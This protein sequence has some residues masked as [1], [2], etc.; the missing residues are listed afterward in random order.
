MPTTIG[1]LA[2]Q[3]GFKGTPH[4][5][6]AEPSSVRTLPVLDNSSPV[7]SNIRT[8]V[9]CYVSGQYVQ[10]NGN[11][12]EVTQRYTIFVAYHKQTQFATMQQVR[13]RIIMDFE[14]KY[15][16]TFNVTNVFVP[17]LPVPKD[18]TFRGVRKGATGDLFM[19]EGSELFREMTKYERA[20]YEIG[21][22]REMASTNISNI[23]QRYGLKR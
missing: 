16:K 15:G 1:E 14:A 3:V 12:I 9:D 10:R 8:S 2:K 20:R 21:T 23:R 19:Y 13:D 5:R 11:V 18:K 4:H 7:A 6:L 22:Q 17:T